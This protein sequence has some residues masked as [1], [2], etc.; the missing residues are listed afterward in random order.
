MHEKS[1]THI[2]AL[3]RWEGARN[4]PEAA[5]MA[6]HV[7]HALDTETA[8]IVTCMKLLYFIVQKDRPIS[9]YEDTCW[10]HM[11]LQTPN[12]PANDDYGSYTSREATYDFL[13][14][15]SSHLKETNLQEV[16]LSPVFSLL[17]DESTDRTLEQHLIVYVCSLA[18]GGMGEPRMH[19]V[20]LLAVSR[21][22]AEVMYTTLMDLLTAREWPLEKI[23][24]LATDGA[25]SMIGSRTGLAARLRERVP[26]LIN[27]HCIAHR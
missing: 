19:F 17:I 23:V 26:A 9:Q 3:R 1:G 27:I 13:W 11:Y 4:T 12:M 24:A 7:A 20:E 15:I 16:N 14:A 21:G 6:R 2:V 25:A 5:A 10:M 18:R 8:R 22:T